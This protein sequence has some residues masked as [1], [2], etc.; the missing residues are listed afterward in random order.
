MY[1]L[2]FN[3]QIGGLETISVELTADNTTW[4]NDCEKSGDIAMITD[5]DGCLLISEYGW[6]YPVLVYDASR[7]LVNY[8][9]FQAKAL[10]R[11]TLKQH[12]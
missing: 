5:L 4:F 3:P 12:E 2:V 6:N 9:R 11:Q 8:D 10:Q 1:L 7:S